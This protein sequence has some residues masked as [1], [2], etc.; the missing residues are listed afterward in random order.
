[1]AID[2]TLG[3]NPPSWRDWVS[4]QPYRLKIKKGQWLEDFDL[5]LRPGEH[6]RGKHF[7]IT[8]IQI[9]KPIYINYEKDMM[10]SH[11]SLPPP[12]LKV[13]DHLKGSG[14]K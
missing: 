5:I 14:E 10:S 4:G 6:V 12:S 1:M 9:Q 2:Q 13:T 11:K 3:K 8:V 7:T